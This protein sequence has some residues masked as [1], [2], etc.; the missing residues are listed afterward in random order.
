MPLTI[1]SVNLR[2]ALTTVPCPPAGGTFSVTATVNGTS[3]G[4]GGTYDV[5][6]YD[7]DPDNATFPPNAAT[8]ARFE[9]LDEVLGA[10]A[11]PGA[12]LA[13]PHVFTLT[14]NNQCEI[15]GA[16]GNSGEQ[17]TPIVARATV[18]GGSD[19]WSNRVM[20]QCG[21]NPTYR[22]REDGER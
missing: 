16:K 3:T 21:S 2:V 20:I 10:A 22:R 13:T 9:L 19:I 18:V 17:Q 8:L 1:T 11:A 15:E 14:C 4:A 6:L 7:V 5:R 12:L